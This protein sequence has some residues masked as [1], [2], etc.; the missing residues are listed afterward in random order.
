MLKTVK[1]N[2]VHMFTESALEYFEYFSHVIFGKRPSVLVPILGIFRVSWKKGT[3]CV[4]P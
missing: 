4:W 2:E 3:L 1:T